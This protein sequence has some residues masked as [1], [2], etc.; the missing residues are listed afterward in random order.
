MTPK[1]VNDPV[2]YG[3]NLQAFAV[4][5]NQFQMLPFNRIKL[6]FN[7]LFGHD[8]CCAS[9]VT[10]N[11]R[12]YENLEQFAYSVKKKLIKSKTVHF[13]ESS[14]RVGKKDIGCM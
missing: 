6:L 13:D 12:C 3:P 2:Q 1:G 10:M 5:L 8:L 9:L 7:E 4:Y 14:M 11:K